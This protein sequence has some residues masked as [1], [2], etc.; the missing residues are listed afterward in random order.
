MI[1]SSPDRVDETLPETGASRMPA[2]RARTAGATDRIVSGST[3]LMSTAT[4]PG[5]RPAATPSGPSY[6]SRTAASSATIEMTTSARDAA[7]AGVA[8]TLAPIRSARAVARSGVR[9]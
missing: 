5:R 9:L 6:S 1:A 7:S 8:A 3:V 4:E 2:P